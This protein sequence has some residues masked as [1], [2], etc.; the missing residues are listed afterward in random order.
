[1]GLHFREGLLRVPEKLTQN[2]IRLEFIEMRD[3]MPETWL[4]EEEDSRKN[5]LSFPQERAAPVMDILQWL[6]CFAAMVGV[7]SRV[8]PTM[9]LEFMSYQTTIIKCARDFHGPAWAQY[10]RAYRHQM[11]QMKDL[12]WSRLNPMLYSLCF[13]GKAKCLVVCAHCLSDSHATDQCPENIDLEQ[14]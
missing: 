7:L 8:Y 13:A 1:M 14:P 6:Q 5:T 3:L 4:M 2:I 9:V 10:D 11:A 12:R